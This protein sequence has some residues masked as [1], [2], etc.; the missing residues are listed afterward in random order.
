MEDRVTH[1]VYN[2]YFGTVS[3]LSVMG[4]MIARA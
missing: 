1:L 2:K 3:A 4:N